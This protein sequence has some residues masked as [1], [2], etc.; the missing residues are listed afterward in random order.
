MTQKT[1][2]SIF[3]LCAGLVFIIDQII[4]L[5]VLNAKKTPIFQSDFIDI[6]LVFNRGVAFS[7]GDVLGDW[8]KWIILILMIILLVVL[9][10]NKELFCAHFVEFGLIF[11]AGIGNLV[12]RFIH[13]AVIDYVFWHYGFN[14][15]V[16]NFA[17]AVINVS[18]AWLLIVYFFSKK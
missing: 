3:A 6:I 10:K 17:D 5:A 18:I 15:A 16:F 7:L 1:R 8:I 2:I 12:D 4:K 11:G 13:N 14:F 9:A